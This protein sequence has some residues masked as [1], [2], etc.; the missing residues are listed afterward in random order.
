[1]RLKTFTI[2][3]VVLAAL[4]LALALGLALGRKQGGAKVEQK[5]SPLVDLA[6]PKPSDEIKN[7]SGTITK[8]YGAIINLEIVDPD[9]Y[10]P[11]TDG[12]PYI[13]EIRLASISSATQITLVDY[14]K[15]DNRGNPT[16]TSIE[17]SNLKTGDTITVQSDENIRDA[18]KFDV[19]RVELIRY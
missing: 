13:K 12:T 7:F 9:D 5:L 16:I 14:T 19:T 2:T 18:K 8:I 6:F 11:H 17:L 3:I 10:L 1:M 15:P 4:A